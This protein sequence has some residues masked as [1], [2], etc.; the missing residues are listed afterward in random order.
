MNCSFVTD[1]AQNVV[2]LLPPQKIYSFLMLNFTYVKIH[3]WQF[4]HF[5]FFGNLAIEIIDYVLS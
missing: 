1:S 3:F 5:Q 4:F 2:T